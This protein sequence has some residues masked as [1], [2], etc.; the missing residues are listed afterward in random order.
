MNKVFFIGLAKLIFIYIPICL[1]V[2]V[3][4]YFVGKVML[5]YN[6]RTF[7]FIP[8]TITIIILLYL[9]KV[10]LG[11]TMDELKRKYDTGRNGGRK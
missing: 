6:L 5:E 1:I 8:I 2:F 11:P 4:C 9:F 3:L 10:L 7:L